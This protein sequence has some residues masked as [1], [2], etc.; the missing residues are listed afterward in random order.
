MR[1]PQSRLISLVVVLQFVA[2][3]LFPWPFRVSSGVFIAT[4]VLLSALLGWALYRRK[5]WGIT[6]TIFVQGMNVIVRV[7]TFFANVYTEGEGLDIAFL[8]TY[9]ASVA[10]S[11]FL[12]SSIDRSEVR[13]EFEA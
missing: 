11:V 2:L 6:L 10:L 13:L 9:I 7:I 5:P 4:L 1:R 3:V 12:L 8:L